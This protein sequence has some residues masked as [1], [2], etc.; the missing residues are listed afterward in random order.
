MMGVWV[1]GNG[2]LEGKGRK[3]KKTGKG[4]ASW[5]SFACASGRWEGE[6][7]TSESNVAED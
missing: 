3:G 4:D 7:S 6:M 1:F 5:G 2:L